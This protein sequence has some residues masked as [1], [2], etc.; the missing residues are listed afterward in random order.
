MITMIQTRVSFSKMLQK[1]PMMNLPAQSRFSVFHLNFTERRFA[2]HR[3]VIIV[4]SCTD[5]VPDFFNV[6]SMEFSGENFFEKWRNS[7]PP[8]FPL[9]KKL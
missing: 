5:C 1:H 6:S 7:V 8:L 4:C 9:I 2:V 3:S